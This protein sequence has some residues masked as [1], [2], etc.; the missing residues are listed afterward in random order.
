MRRYEDKQFFQR[1]TEEAYSTNR[2]D[3]DE[4]TVYRQFLEAM[5]MRPD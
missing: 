2:I 1:W 3:A 5:S 4:H